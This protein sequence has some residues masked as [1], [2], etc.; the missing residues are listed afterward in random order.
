MPLRNCRTWIAAI[1]SVWIPAHAQAAADAGRVFQPV[2]TALIRGGDAAQTLTVD[3]DGLE[4]LYLVVTFG[5]DNY[6]SDQAIWAEPKLIGRDGRAV[7]LTTLEPGRVQVGW[8]RLFTNDNQKGQPLRIGGTTFETGFWA[9]GPSLLHFKLDGKYARFETRVGIDTGAG[10]NGSVHFEVTNVAPTIPEPSVYK[11]TGGAPAVKL[12]AS[13]AEEAPHRFNAEAAKTLLERGVEKL[14]FVRRFTLTANHVYTEYVNSRWTP[15]GGLAVLDLETGVA[16]DLLPELSEGVVNRF[17]LSYDAKRIV[18]DYKKSAGEGYRIHEIGVDGKGLRQ[19]TFPV[20]DEEEL[21]RKYG[22]PGYHHGT[23]D[24]HPCYLPDGD[25]AF[26]STRCRYGIL[27]NAADVYTTKVLFRMDA[28]GGKLRPLSNSPVSE[29]SPA[30]LPDGRIVYHRWEY[31]DKAAGNLKCLW[32]MNPD[33]TATA[34][35]YGN[36]ITFPETMIYP[37][38]I[39]GADGKIVMLGTSHCCPNN[40]MG[41]VVVIDTSSDLRSPETMQ[42]VTDDVRA[43]EHTGF[44]FRDAAGEWKHD[45]TGTLGRLFKDPFP[46]SEDLFIAARK[47]KGPAWNDPKAYGLCLLDGEGNETLL[48][49]DEEISC[50]HPYPLQSRRLP[51]VVVSTPNPKLADEGLAL[52]VVTDVYTGMEQV[53]RGTVKH[54]RILEEVP[55]PW[56]TRKKW[57]RDDRD[58]MAHSAIGDGFLGLKVQHGVVPVEDDGS[59][60]FYVPAMRNIYLQALDERYR[61][62]QTERTYV[63]YMPGETRS[64]IG[65]HETPNRMQRPP[66][67]AP[68]AMTRPPSVASPQPG[69]AAAA[70]LFDYDRQIQP[71]W[72]RHCVECHNGERAEGSLNLVGDPEG[73]YSVSY[74]NLI[75]LGKTEKQ[76]LGCRKP[77]N[78]NVGSAGIEYLP[79]SALGALTS[80]LAAMLSRGKITLRDS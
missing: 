77:R 39:P 17:D 56:A 19:L 14:V 4:D 9:H 69:E 27:C 51:P 12:T 68:M 11:Q 46:L 10:Q 44:H 38:P 52:C 34:E 47:P 58:G 78:E 72:D 2:R 18:F 79:P 33:G 26:V 75:K 55:R 16:K 32:S 65:C 64:C 31:V 70:R 15:G 60:R 20:E 74:H 21:V 25:I 29:A 35:V 73:V 66:A 49:E 3:V 7:D 23:D 50:W 59:A 41:A 45:K 24:M 67:G 62:V 54:L 8:G 40:A 53:K 13:A 42:F 43:L 71:I 28:D 37:R 1:V 22:S 48:Y 76:L 63:H 36:T 6:R 5:D 57:F 80:P 30:M 61:A